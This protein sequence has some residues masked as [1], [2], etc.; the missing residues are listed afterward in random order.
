MIKL[1]SNNI[2]YSEIL[3][4]ISQSKCLVDIVQDGQEGLTYRPLEALFY[5][6]K[7]ITN[8]KTITEYD[9]YKEENIYILGKDARSLKK[10]IESDFV[11]WNEKIV[12]KYTIE[13]WIKNF[14]K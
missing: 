3:N 5:N 14:F 13:N 8:N 9:F 12:K 1:I 7:L 11:P 4:N 10:F 2:S 6:K